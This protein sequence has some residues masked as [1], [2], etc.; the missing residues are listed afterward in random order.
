MSDPEVVASLNLKVLRL[1]DYESYQLPFRAQ[2]VT[3]ADVFVDDLRADGDDSLD[4]VPRITTFAQLKDVFKLDIDYSLGR[5]STPPGEFYWAVIG[6]YLRTGTAAFIPKVLAQNGQPV[7]APG[8]FVFAHWPGAPEFSDT[9]NP[10]YHSRAVGGFT[11]VNGDVG[12]GYS[13]GAVTGAGGGVYDI[14]VSA[15]PPFGTRFYSDAAIRLGWWGGTDHLTPNPIFQAVRKPGAQPPTGD[16]R[17]VIYD[18]QGVE[19]G[20]LTLVTDGG[21]GRIA[22]VVNDQEL[23]SAKLE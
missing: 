13:G 1:T 9:P 8:A 10:L 16:S 18:K 17:L 12:F 19:V 6:F 20:F 2:A 14:W 4:L 23:S 22:L 3:D 21:G 11:N 7:P 15:D 5:D